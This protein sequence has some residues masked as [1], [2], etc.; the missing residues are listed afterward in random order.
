M[1]NRPLNSE[2]EIANLAESLEIV[3]N[4]LEDR[5]EQFMVDPLSKEEEEEETRSVIDR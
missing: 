4:L 1:S 2:M 5:S 3:D